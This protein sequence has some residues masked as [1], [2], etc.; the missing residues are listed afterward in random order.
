MA[1]EGATMTDTC[2]NLYYKLCR[3]WTMEPEN[4]CNLFTYSPASSMEWLTSEVK[5]LFWEYEQLEDGCAQKDPAPQEL[6]TGVEVRMS[7]GICAIKYQ[8]INES[9][10]AREISV[11]TNSAATLASTA[12]LAAAAALLF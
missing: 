4:T 1:N 11:M 10:I 7:A 5:V 9:E 12:V 3:H 6:L 8:I 2:T